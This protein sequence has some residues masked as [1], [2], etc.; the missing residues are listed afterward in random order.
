VTKRA[1]QTEWDRILGRGG[2]VR[3]AGRE[4]RET[5]G[6]GIYTPH[7]TG[8]E[9]CDS[10]RSTLVRIDRL[11]GHVCPPCDSSLDEMFE[12]RSP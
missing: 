8:C 11:R 6:P 2:L 9:H 10:E 4:Y 5:D 1:R 12:E 3:V 7:G